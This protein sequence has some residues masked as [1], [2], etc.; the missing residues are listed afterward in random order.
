MYHTSV[1]EQMH[2]G[3]EGGHFGVERTL[4]CLKTRYYW[5]TMRD[6]VTLWCQTCNDCT[7]KACPKKTPQA[8]MGTVQVGTLMERIAVSLIAISNQD[9]EAQSLHTS[10]TGLLQQMGGSICNSKRAGI[11]SS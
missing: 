5:Y 11:D 8:A 1:L 7:E 2:D 9:G 6:N 3:P 10:G 4:K